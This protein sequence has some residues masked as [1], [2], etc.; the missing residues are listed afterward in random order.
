M[1][2][3]LPTYLKYHKGE[4]QFCW[5]HFKRNI[6]GVLDIAKTTEAERFCRD[7]LA[8]HA[9][10]FRLWHW[11]FGAG[12]GIRYGPKTREQLIAKSIP[13]EKK[14]FA[15]ADRYSDSRDMDVRNLCP[16]VAEAF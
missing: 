14:F 13:L 4:G 12:P 5:A 3:S 8:L 11:G 7:G 6:L 16:G 9:R 1:Q 2:R 10:L 15:L